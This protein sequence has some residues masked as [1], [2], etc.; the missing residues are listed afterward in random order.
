MPNWTDNPENTQAL[1]QQEY[2]GI[3]LGGC[4]KAC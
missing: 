4:R 2:I 3:I 1:K